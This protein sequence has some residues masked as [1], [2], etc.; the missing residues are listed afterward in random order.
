M[1][2]NES[3]RHWYTA[4]NAYRYF[5]EH[6]ENT[7]R[8]WTSADRLSPGRQRLPLV[9]EDFAKLRSDEYPIR[10]W[11]VAVFL[12]GA[13][14]LLQK[15]GIGRLL[16]GDEFDTTVR[17]S[18]KGIPHYG[19]LY[20]QSRYFDNGMSR[21]FRRKG[22]GVAQFS[23]L[24]PMSELLIEKTLVERYPELQQY[25]LSCHAAHIDEERVRPC[26]RCEKCRRI[27][28]MLVALGADPARCGFNA[29][30]IENALDALGHLGVHQE[31][32]GAEHLVAMLT[33]RGKIDGAGARLHSEITK[34]RFTREASP[35]DGLPNDLREPLYR[36]MLEHADGA[37]R[38]SGRLWVEY[39]PLC[40]ESLAAPYRFES[41]RGAS[42]TTSNKG[43]LWAELTWLEA[44]RRLAEVDVALLPVGAIE[45]HGSHLPVDVDAYDADQLCRDVA[46]RSSHPR[47]LVLPLISY[48]VS[49]HHDDFP[50]RLASR[51][52]RW[53]GS[54][55]RWE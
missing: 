33:E 5:K 46:A 45:Q 19:G 20:D 49:Y 38:R 4:I 6:V 17:L 48:G 15:R 39:D 37:L 8:V 41:R 52:T 43:Y 28:G 1:F 22:F 53:S 51:Q 18:F 32:A 21:F 26:G 25:Q 23:A 50:V 47:P 36:I 54:P 29:E 14:P 27:V 12:F 31:R 42:S 40:D 10:L 44:Q 34:L 9:R 35:L 7:A 24:R 16:I 2:L 3:G 30:Q 11:T 13:L 55:T